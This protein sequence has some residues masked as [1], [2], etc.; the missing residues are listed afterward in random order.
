MEQ[1]KGSDVDMYRCFMSGEGEKNTKWKLGVPPNFDVVNKLFEEGRTKIN[2]AV[3]EQRTRLVFNTIPLKQIRRLFPRV[4]RPKL[5]YSRTRQSDLK[6][7]GKDRGMRRVFRVEYNR[8]NG[9]DKRCQVLISS[10]IK[11]LQVTNTGC[12]LFLV[13]ASFTQ[14]TISSIPIGG[15]ICPEGFLPSIMLMMIMVMVVIVAIILVVVVVVIFGVVVVVSG[16]SSIIKLSFMII[17]FSRMIMFY[18]LLHQPLGYGNGFLQSLRLQTVTF[19]SILLSNPPMK[20][21]MSFSEFGTMF[22]K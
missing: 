11:A 12:R 14:G 4:Q 10:D 2:K 8:T 18:Y 9:I 1:Y 3:K 6:D 17:G 15:S 20:T 19:P 13:G 5:L 7:Y 21:S 16:V 22:G